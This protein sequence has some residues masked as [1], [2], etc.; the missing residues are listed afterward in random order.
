MT[1]TNVHVIYIPAF[2]R[3]KITQKQL[4]PLYLLC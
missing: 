1:Y 3:N 4:D 2:I